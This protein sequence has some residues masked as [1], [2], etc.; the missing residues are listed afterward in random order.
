MPLHLSFTVLLAFLYYMGLSGLIG[1]TK[2]RASQFR[3]QYGP[4]M[5]CLP[6]SVLVLLARLEDPGGRDVVGWL[7][8]LFQRIVRDLKSVRPMGRNESALVRSTVSDCDR[9]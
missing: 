2:K 4:Q 8:S 6:L 7:R 9:C 1:L 3:S 5:Q